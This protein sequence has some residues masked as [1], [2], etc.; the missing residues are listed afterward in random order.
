MN[1]STHHRDHF[2]ALVRE[3]MGV[4]DRASEGQR[5]SRKKVERALR[6]TGDVGFRREIHD[7][8]RF[9]LADKFAAN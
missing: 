5:I 4:L 6:A 9:A 2:P 7:P 8:S 1:G 3:A